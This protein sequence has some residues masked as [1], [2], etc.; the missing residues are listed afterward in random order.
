MTGPL[1][2]DAAPPPGKEP[3]L[4]WALRQIE[5]NLRTLRF[6]SLTLHVQ[7]GVVVQ[8]ERLAKTRYQRGDEEAERTS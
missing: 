7:D 2:G 4:R 6:G 8:V 5:E 1:T 3:N